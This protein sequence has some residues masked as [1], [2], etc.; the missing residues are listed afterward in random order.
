M[1][2]NVLKYVFLIFETWHVCVGGGD[3]QGESCSENYSYSVSFSYCTVS[4]L[5]SLPACILF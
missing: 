4:D 3:A 1:F 2:E 5:F